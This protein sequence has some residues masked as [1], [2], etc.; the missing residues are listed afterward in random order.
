MEKPSQIIDD[1]AKLAGGAAGIAG[2]MQQQIRN[3]IKARIDEMAERMDLVPREDFE[4][5]E[6][7][8]KTLEARI[9]ELESKK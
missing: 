6:A 8:T 7:L 1:L 9:V 3:D 2:S 5:L 4:R